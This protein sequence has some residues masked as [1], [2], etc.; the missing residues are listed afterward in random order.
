[1]TI[2][3]GILVLLAFCLLAPATLAQQPPDPPVQDGPMMGISMVAQDAPNAPPGLPPGVLVQEAMEGTPAEKAG[4]KPGDLIT[5]FD[6]KEVTGI[7]SIQAL[8]P[9]YSIGDTIEVT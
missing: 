5:K 1:M 8:M 2:H 3:R 6:G 9:T 7:K 4:L